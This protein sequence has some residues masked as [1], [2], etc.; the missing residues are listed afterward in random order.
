MTEPL[1]K[2]IKYNIGHILVDRELSNLERYKCSICFDTIENK[3]IYQ[4]KEGHWKCRECWIKFLLK[5]KECMIC[6]CKINSISEL[7][8][9]RFLEEEFENKKVYCP[10]SF[11]ISTNSNDPSQPLLIRDEIKGCNK[12]ITINQIDI[13]LSECKFK[14]KYLKYIKL[15]DR[16]NEMEKTIEKLQSLS[17]PSPPQQPTPYSIENKI[18]QQSQPQPLQLVYKNKWFI[19][20]YPNL[21]KLKVNGQSIKTPVFQVNGREFELAVFPNGLG[22]DQKDFLSVFL[23]LK[24]I[25]SPIYVYYSIEFINFKYP[26]KNIEHSIF[27]SKNL[28]YGKNKIIK[29]SEITKEEGWLSYD[30]KLGFIIT[31]ELFPDYDYEKEQK[32][33]EEM[34]YYSYS[35]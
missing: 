24:T 35:L 3:E 29:V 6:R 32:K 18:D 25:K 15:L 4:C 34:K 17:S 27:S 1:T 19:P 23:Y 8:R 9:N 28:A 22:L 13:H 10:N 2:F 20:N 21:S 12:I 30:D 5:K 31:V 11:K 16:I 14:C 7:S 33:K 26:H